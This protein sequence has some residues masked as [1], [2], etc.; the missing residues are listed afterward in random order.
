M[1]N[2]CPDL[3]DSDIFHLHDPSALQ[4]YKYTDTCN[5]SYPSYPTSPSFNGQQGNGER[6]GAIYLFIYAEKR[7][8][9]IIKITYYNDT[10][11]VKV[12]PK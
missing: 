9:L 3:I 8:L 2:E 1:M 4:S 7:S 11:L 10:S 5:S 12:T 6:A